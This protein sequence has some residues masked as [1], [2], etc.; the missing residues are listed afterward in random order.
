MSSTEIILFIINRPE[1][2]LL[3]RIYQFTSVM[4]INF[5]HYY[6]YYTVRKAAYIKFLKK[7]KKIS[8]EQKKTWT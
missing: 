5:V 1:K 8:I 2:S 6:Y 3:Y 4:K 7:K